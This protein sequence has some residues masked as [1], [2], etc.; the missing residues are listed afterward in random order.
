MNA[1][2]TS[3]SSSSDDENDMWFVRRPKR[4]RKRKNYLEIF[5]ELDFFQR[6]RITKGTFT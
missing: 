2:D 6:F 1:I 5:D 3:S 4:Y